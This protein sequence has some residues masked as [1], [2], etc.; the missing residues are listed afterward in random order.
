[1]IRAAL[2]LP[3]RPLLRRDVIPRPSVLIYNKFSSEEKD[4]YDRFHKESKE[5][6]EKL[7]TLEF[8]VYL[9]D[10]RRITVKELESTLQTNPSAFML[11]F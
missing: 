7:H 3:P 10:G 9:R 4:L 6:L 5:N 2:P 11:M 1:M 8:F